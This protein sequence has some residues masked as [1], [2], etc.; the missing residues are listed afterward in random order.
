MNVITPGQHITVDECMSSW[1]GGESAYRVE[2]MPH[3]TKIA[4]KLEGVGAE[5]KALCDGNSGILLRLDIME[6]KQR[7]A[8]KE[9]HG[10]FGE[11]T[12][13]TLRLT[14][15]Y[16]GTNRTIHADSAF[17]SVKTAEALQ[18][19][20]YGHCQNCS[21]RVSKGVLRGLGCWQG[22]WSSAGTWRPHP[23]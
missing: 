6:G 20:L 23:T 2:G 18:T 16:F 3:K 8:S 5:M 17:S 14:K 7:Q 10:E 11:G 22:Y 1:K 15:D 13:V 4:R 12:A 19:A 9:F 21:Q